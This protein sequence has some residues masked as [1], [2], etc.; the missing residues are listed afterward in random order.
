M[1][2]VVYILYVLENIIWR[3]A[4][5][6]RGRF[7]LSLYIYFSL[8]LLVFFITTLTAHLLQ[9]ITWSLPCPPSAPVACWPSVTNDHHRS[10][11]CILLP[12]TSIPYVLVPPSDQYLLCCRATL[13]SYQHFLWEIIL[14]HKP[15]YI[16]FVGIKKALRLN[17]DLK[18]L[19]ENYVLQ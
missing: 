11:L 15:T 1:L 12:C 7:N 5:I 13:Y 6:F 14:W 2:Y 8:L 19:K 18:N 9:R 4:T 3:I 17:R 10:M 16:Y